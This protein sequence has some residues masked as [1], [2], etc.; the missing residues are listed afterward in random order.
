ME[1]KASKTNDQIANEADKK[2]DIVAI[3]EAAGNSFVC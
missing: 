1:A 3:S 2:V